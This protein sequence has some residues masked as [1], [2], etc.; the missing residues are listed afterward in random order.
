MKLSLPL[1]VISFGMAVFGQS[2]HIKSAGMFIMGLFHIKISNSYTHMYELVHEKDKAMATTVINTIDD[3]SILYIAAAVYYNRDLNKIFVIAWSLA[4]VASVL[5][6]MLIPE[7]PRWLFFTYGPKSAKGIKALN[8]IAWVNG[9]KN[10]VPTDARLDLINDMIQENDKNLVKST[11]R[12][13]A[14]SQ[15]K[16][17]KLS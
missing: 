17:I 15:S 8:Y 4:F 9:S 5:Y 16:S 14:H 13:L 1:Q 12:M 7:S 6:L 2:I 11:T 3:G 10:R